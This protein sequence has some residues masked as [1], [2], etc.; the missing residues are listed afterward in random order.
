M[1]NPRDVSSMGVI[2]GGTMGAGI[3]TA[4]LLAG[5]PVVLIEM[6]E[7]GVAAARG[8]IEG[9]LQGALKRG[10]I[11]QAQYDQLT[12]GALTVAT[13][14]AALG[15]VDLV[16]EAVF[17]DMGV[18]REVFGKLDAHCKPGAVSGDQYLLSGCR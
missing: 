5:L 13:D 7:E 1:L 11:T 4:A 15:Q 14:Y 12:G 6:T 16:V 9:N 10:K 8:R 17:E 2:G 3:A 18:K